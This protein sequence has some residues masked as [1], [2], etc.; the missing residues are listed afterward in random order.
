MEDAP[1]ARAEIS[2]VFDRAGLPLNMLTKAEGRVAGEKWFGGGEVHTLVYGGKGK[3]GN[4][5]G[6]AAVMA[7]IC[8]IIARHRAKQRAVAKAAAAKPPPPPPRP[9]APGK[10][11]KPSKS[12]GPAVTSMRTSADGAA[13]ASKAAEAVRQHRKVPSAEASADADALAVVTKAL[14]VD[15]QEVVNIA[16]TWDAYFAWHFR[17]YTRLAADAEDAAI[18]AHGLKMLHLAIALKEMFEEASDHGSAPSHGT[19]TSP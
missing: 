15:A 19:P 14:G 12:K 7:E 6:G 17:L 10:I 5:P 18:D 11:A 3:G 4:S 1:D 13:A 16:L 2:A 8:L 9:A